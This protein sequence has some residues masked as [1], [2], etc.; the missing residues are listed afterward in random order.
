LILFI[1]FPLFQDS[2]LRLRESV[3]FFVEF[4]LKSGN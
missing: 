1:F 3:D 2:E 4:Y